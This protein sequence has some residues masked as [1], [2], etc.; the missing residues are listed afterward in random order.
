MFRAGGIGNRKTFSYW[1]KFQRLKITVAQICLRVEVKRLVLNYWGILVINK[2]F[3]H[4]P[5][6]SKTNRYLSLIT[7]GVRERLASTKNY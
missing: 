4:P 3:C 6:V 1:L 5:I 7:R 2:E